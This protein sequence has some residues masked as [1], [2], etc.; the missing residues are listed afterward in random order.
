[1]HSGT[2]NR[3]VPL[4][5]VHKVRWSW[6]GKVDALL[7]SAGKANIRTYSGI[8]TALSSYLRGR[9]S[10]RGQRPRASGWE[11]VWALSAGSPTSPSCLTVEHL[12]PS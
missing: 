1:M 11:P 4:K 5:R 7:D 6:V 9:K 10:R 2:I 12:A 8:K 3:E